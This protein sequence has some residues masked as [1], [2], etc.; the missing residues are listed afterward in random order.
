MNEDINIQQ[1]SYSSLAD[2]ARALTLAVEGHLMSLEE[3]KFLWKRHL[4]V[5]GW[6]KVESAPETEVIKKTTKIKVETKKS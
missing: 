3:A 4:I 5:A 2:L 1:M 6:K